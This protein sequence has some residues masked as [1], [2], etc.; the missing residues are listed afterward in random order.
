MYWVGA[1]AVKVPLIGVL[2]IRSL[3]FGGY[4]RAWFLGNSSWGVVVSGC[5]GVEWGG[6]RPTLPTCCLNSQ[7]ASAVLRELLSYMLFWA[8]SSSKTSYVFAQPFAAEC[9]TASSD[10][11]FAGTCWKEL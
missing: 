10:L 8:I 4:I 2:A 3:L 7:S 9:I 6:T 1:S 5:G 11:N